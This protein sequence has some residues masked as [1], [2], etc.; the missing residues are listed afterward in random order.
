MNKKKKKRGNFKKLSK[1]IKEMWEVFIKSKKTQKVRDI[2]QHPRNENVSLCGR[3]FRVGQKGSSVQYTG[4][5]HKLHDMFWPDTEENPEKNEAKKRPPLIKQSHYIPS[6]GMK[7]DCK[8]Y[9]H[10]H[11]TKVHS[12]IN[13][14]VQRLKAGK[15]LRISSYL[16]PCTI[17]IIRLLNHKRWIPFSS[18]FAIYDEDSKVATAIDILVFDIRKNEMIM[19][20]LKTGYETEE[21]GELEEDER[22]D[23]INI[24]NSPRNRHSLQLLWMV[25]I[26][27][28]KYDIKIDDALILR[29][30]PKQKVA[31]LLPLE[32]WCMKKK[33]QK[34]FIESFEIN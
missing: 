20:E 15:P 10:L 33:F 8:T 4:L 30:L 28:K 6:K 7:S 2:I 19:L 21:Y 34:K 5:T 9:G 14:F 1:D 22:M 31:M 17:R 13:K 27:K 3:S 23:M 18:E 29:I 26:L 32:K 25:L 11:G 12:Q 16:D 24:K